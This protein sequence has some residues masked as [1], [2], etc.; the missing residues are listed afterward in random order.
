M[1]GP[2]TREEWNDIIRRVNNKA[3]NPEPEDSSHEDGTPC[4]PLDP[5]EEV[6]PNHIW[7]VSDVEEVQDKLKEMCPEVQFT[8]PLI[9][10]TQNLI[11]EI[12][13]AIDQAWC[14][15][16]NNC[17]DL[18]S[19]AVEE[20]SEPTIVY[21]GSHSGSGCGTQCGDWL[22]GNYRFD[23]S[24]ND[25]SGEPAFI[26]Y[27]EWID[28]NV[29]YSQASSD[30]IQ[31]FRKA[32]SLEDEIEQLEEEIE[33]LEEDIESVEEVISE[34]CGREG[35]ESRCEQARAQKEELETEK[36]EKEDEKEEKEE[37][38][39]EEEEK[40]DEGKSKMEGMVETLAEK[41]RAINC[42]E[43]SPALDFA[44]PGEEP[45]P[46]E[47]CEFLSGC[48]CPAY[49]IDCNWDFACP[50]KC[51]VTWIMQQRYGGGSSGGDC[52]QGECIEFWY[53]FWIKI[54][55]KY[56][57]SCE[58]GDSAGPGEW[59]TEDF[60]WQHSQHRVAGS[61]TPDGAA[62]T[63]ARMGKRVAGCG[64]AVDQCVYSTHPTCGECGDGPGCDN[65]TTCSVEYR[66]LITYPEG[67]GDGGKYD[68]NCESCEEEQNGGGA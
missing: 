16:E 39:A 62:V 22:C 30:Y 20:G 32:C 24:G 19:N 59:P 50:G 36:Q 6:G 33:Q 37:E 58:G 64:Y 29:E 56:E 9:L 11:D 55:S 40:R 67:P 4:D 26:A 8:D 47:D 12:E 23:A 66:T 18:C 17:A 60:S 13:E 54:C 35:Y 38:L 42:P 68:C 65:D 15:C 49:G 34:V 41:N 43:G 31:G 14:D 46:H 3:E 5:I 25:R 1:A 45:W 48:G 27:Q 51:Q 10:W 7:A 53:L 2:Y 28:A 44:Q 52:E 57:Y 63:T 21:G 61:Y